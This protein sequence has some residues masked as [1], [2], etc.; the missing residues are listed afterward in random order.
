MGEKVM[1]LGL[2]FLSNG[3][4]HFVCNNESWIIDMLV[5]N[6]MP[7]QISTRS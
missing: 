3:K 4:C 1:L 7:P 6:M 2:G 5:I